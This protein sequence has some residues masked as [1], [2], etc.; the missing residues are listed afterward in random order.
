MGKGTLHKGQNPKQHIF[1]T[2]KLR[3]QET[4]DRW[5]RNNFVSSAHSIAENLCS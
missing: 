4:A 3:P 1:P 5:A 2:P